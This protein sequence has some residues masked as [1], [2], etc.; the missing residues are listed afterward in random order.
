MLAIMASPPDAS[1]ADTEVDVEL[2]LDGSRE[3]WI[4]LSGRVIRL[5]QRAVAISFTTVPATFLDLMSDSS[6]HSHDHGRVMT[7]VLVD[8]TQSRRLALAEAFRAAGCKVIDVTT[9]LQAIVQLGE[10]R[11]EP[12]LIAIA[13]SLPTTTA[14]EL[15]QFVEHE[16]PRAQLVTIG[17]G[18]EPEGLAHWLSSVPEDLVKRIRTLLFR[19]RG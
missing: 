13:D 1:V 17:E 8:A 16:H 12:E 15:R 2:R 9:P 5:D 18:T 11:F 14:A 10:Q 7:V 19:P 6:S 4:Q 3:A